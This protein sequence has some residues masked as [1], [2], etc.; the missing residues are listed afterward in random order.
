MRQRQRALVDHGAEQIRSS[1]VNKAPPGLAPTSST[2]K[3][4]VP[5]TTGSARSGRAPAVVVWAEIS[6]VGEASPEQEPPTRRAFRPRG[7]A[8]AGCDRRAA[9]AAPCARWL[10]RPRRAS[11]ADQIHTELFDAGLVARARGKHVH[12]DGMQGQHHQDRRHHS[13]GRGSDGC[14]AKRHAQLGG[15]G[16]PRRNGQRARERTDDQAGE[17]ARQK[18][19]A[20]PQVVANE[21]EGHSYRS[22]GESRVGEHVG[23]RELAHQPLAAHDQ[24]NRG[25]RWRHR[26][27]E[28]A[29]DVAPVSLSKQGAHEKGEREEEEAGAQHADQSPCRRRASASE[30]EGHDEGHR[31]RDPRR[32]WSPAPAKGSGEAKERRRAAAAQACRARR[33][34]AQS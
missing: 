3:R 20:T 26:H 28:R 25:Q 30:H 17:D 10:D 15:Q 7:R 12:L 8:P 9:S 5:N 31:H 6:S 1:L 13:A 4:S 34:A 11:D 32:R 16:R 27:R 22:E 19:A 2:P 14:R 23:V 24:S 21:C 18:R 33:G 29:Q